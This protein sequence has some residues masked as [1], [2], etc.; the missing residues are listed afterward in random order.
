MQSSATSAG[1]LLSFQKFFAFFFPL[2]QCHQN[3]TLSLSQHPN[4]TFAKTNK[5][6]QTGTGS[7]NPS[8]HVATWLSKKQVSQNM[9][10]N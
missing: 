3:T 6:I 10:G 5:N 1:V 4:E 8:T 9:K 2:C 7:L